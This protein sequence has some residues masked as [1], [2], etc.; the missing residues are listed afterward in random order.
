MPRGSK[1]GERRGGRQRGTPNKSTLLKNAAIKAAGSDPNLSPLDFLLKLMR[2]RDLPL[3]VRVKVAQQALPFAHSKPKAVRSTKNTYGGSQIGV[4]V[5]PGPRVK[6]VKVKSDDADVDSITPLDF[7]LGVMRDENS[8]TPLRLKVT[9]IVAP[10]VHPKGEPNEVD[11]TGVEMKVVEDPYGFDPKMLK[12]LHQDVERLR[13]LEP[14]GLD[15][16]RPEYKAELQKAKQTPEYLE[17][18][19]RIADKFPANYNELDSRQDRARLTELE[20]ESKTR[21]L[22]ATEEVEQKHLQARLEVYSQTPQ[23]ADCQSYEFSQSIGG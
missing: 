14:S 1:P 10:Y 18:E 5:R 2:Q 20:A 7:L 19:K 11:E 15:C 21:P 12:S 16:I 22:T 3:E 17:L 9:G 8:P 6:V 23:G 4:N 13:A